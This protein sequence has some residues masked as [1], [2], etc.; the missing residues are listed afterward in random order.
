MNRSLL[1]VAAATLLVVASCASCANPPPTIVEAAVVSDTDVEAGPYEARVLARDDDGIGEAFITWTTGD[2]RDGRVD[3]VAVLDPTAELATRLAGHLPGQPLG[4]V[5]RWTATV[6]DTRGECAVAPSRGAFEFRVG[7]VPSSPRLHAVTPDHGPAS[8]GTRVELRGADL[9]PGV[10]VTFGDVEAAHV[11]FV[12]TD[13][14]V[15]TSP[16]AA[17]G[18]V[19]V[20]V[21]N[22]DGVTAALDDAY[23]FVPSPVV[24]GVDPAS[25]PTSGDTAVVITGEAFVEDARAF[26]DGVPCRHQVRVDE[27]RI[28]CD[29]PPGRAGLVDVA[30]RS[31]ERGEG[32][33]AGAFEYIPPPLVDA[34][35]PDSGTS[36]GG[37]VITI[38]GDAFHPGSIV[39]VGDEPCLDVVFVDETTL[40]CTTPPGE[41]GV[42][43]VVVVNPDG[44]DGVLP[45]GFA[46]LGPPVIVEVIPG[47]VPVAGGVEVRVLGA[48]LDPTDTVSFG[49]ALGVVVGSSGPEELDVVVPAVPAA[50]EPAPLSGLLAVD[51][52]VTRTQPRDTRSGTLTGGL[53]YF[54]PPEIT[55]VIPPQGPTSGGTDVVVVG[56]F[57]LEI[58]GEDFTVFF[59]DEECLDVEVLSSTSLSCTTPAGDPGLADVS[60]Q[61]HPDSTG[62]G[63][64]VYT[65]LAPPDV[66]R[67]DPPEGP[68]FGGDVVHVHGRF[69]QNGALV[70]IDD[71][72]CTDVQFVSDT[73]LVCTTPPGQEGPADVRVLNPDDQEDTAP[74]IY[75]YLGV[76]VTPDH[77]LPVGFTRVRVRS[78]GIDPAA[79]V[80]FDGVAA[81]CTFVSSREMS[82]QTP[83]HARGPVNVR[84][85]NPD[86]TGEDSDAAFTYRVL[87]DHTNDVENGQEN[88]THVELADLD[89]DGDLD[90]AGSAGQVNFPETSSV[91]ENAGAQ[92]FR[93]HP[94]DVVATA[95][96][97]SI[98]DVVGDA[99]P[100]LLLAASSGVGAVLLRNTGSFDFA[101]VD[102][103][104]G[105]ASSAFD[106][107]LIDVVGDARPDIY[108]LSIGCSPFD[109]LAGA[110]DPSTIGPDVLLERTANGFANRSSLVPHDPDWTHDH[111][112]MATDLDLDGDN[113]IV[114]ITNNEGAF[115]GEQNRVLINR[116]DEGRGFVVDPNQPDLLALTGDLYDIDAADVDGDGDPDVTTTICQPN[117][118]SSEV[119]L[120]NDGGRLVRVS[121]ALPSSFDNCD[122]G[123]AFIDIDDD[124]DPDLF[125]GGT[126]S[127]NDTR[128]ETK[129][130]VNDGTGTFHDAGD[131]LPSFGDDR[132]Q[133]NTFA[134]GDLDGDGDRDVALA[135]GS[136]YFD[137][138]P[139]RVVVWLLE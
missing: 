57:F 121:A 120:R 123:T 132:L 101:N 6:C 36:D 70:F 83:A 31:V 76:A 96:R 99:K 136:P 55:E 27:T 138:Q 89:G 39:L 9:R 53:V 112:L 20:R 17:P 104:L 56:R 25:G 41:P 72:P 78:A 128:A 73:E 7:L 135:G 98:A 85:R 50:L 22:P 44:Q 119:L 30:V 24:T 60:V 63:E 18:L 32:V 45:G 69:F 29:T 125:Y 111:K 47:L 37:D 2:G 103:G 14:V 40:V 52:V 95:N 59:D 58:P 68:T 102:L 16:A 92:G 113:D 19:D 28:E 81:S 126:N 64:G 75:E 74:G 46:F 38:T 114:I 80:T 43:D 5:V 131:A 4:S 66:E 42:A 100:D 61:N 94:L 1:V 86:G 109:P 110:C 15:A 139:G 35:D 87:V 105:P 127:L 93:R 51:V 82:C 115:G 117:S 97:V 13:L 134:G 88:I 137:A 65:Y 8:G 106:A 54:W 122:V 11:E 21:E 77:G 48:G 12:R 67:V 71:A 49:G 62:V 90:I 124:G 23:T 107:Q 91:W 133:I 3:L 130:Y 34:V 10:R 129:L 79:V 118:G 26:F 108:V 84:F 116:V 33:L